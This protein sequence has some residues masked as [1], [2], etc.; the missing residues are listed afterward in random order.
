MHHNKVTSVLKSKTRIIGTEVD[1]AAHVN[2][3]LSLTSYNIRR[4]NKMVIT[5][6]SCDKYFVCRSYT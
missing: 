4:K 1:T 2:I 6:K 5:K 3:V